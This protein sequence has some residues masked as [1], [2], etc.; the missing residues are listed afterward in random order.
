M[1]NWPGYGSEASVYCWPEA[2]YSSGKA[3]VGTFHVSKWVT[4]CNIDTGPV[5]RRF[6][7]AISTATAGQPMGA[8][9]TVSDYTL[10]LE[11]IPQDQAPSLAS[12]CVNRSSTGSVTDLRSLC[13]VVGTNMSQTNKTFMVLYGCKA[14]NFA[15][16]MEEGKEVVYTADF[17]V[18]SVNRR[19]SLVAGWT[20]PGT[21]P[22]GAYIHWNKSGLVINKTNTTLIAS[23]VKSFNMTVDNQ[24]EDHWN[25]GSYTKKSHSIPGNIKVDGS[26]SLSLDDGGNIWLSGQLTAMTNLVIGLNTATDLFKY[27]KIYQA[28]WDQN[29][30][31]ISEKSGPMFLDAKF[32]ASSASFRKNI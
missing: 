17:S 23:I 10:H 30:I 15:M 20:T 27:V 28:Y 18:A 8:L 14:K 22:S 5:N 6:Y 21:L 12:Y 26:C 1:T 13:F 24:L 32:W 7:S 3:S 2:S 29:T 9:S 11:W 4:A 19:T 16:K 31:P 25:Q